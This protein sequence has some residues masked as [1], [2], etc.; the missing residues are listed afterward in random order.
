MNLNRRTNDFFSNHKYLFAVLYGERSIFLPQQKNASPSLLCVLCVKRVPSYYTFLCNTRATVLFT[1]ASYYS[2]LAS[3]MR[4]SD[5]MTTP[6]METAW[7]RLFLTT[8]TGSMTPQRI[9]SS[10]FSDNA[11]KPKL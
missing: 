8:F 1:Q 10:T 9:K 4:A 2:S 11:L 3:E 6:A 7:V 5:R